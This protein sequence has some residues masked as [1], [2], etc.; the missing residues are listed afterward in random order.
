MFN[1]DGLLNKFKNISPPD[2]SIKNAVSEAVLEAIKVKIEKTKIKVVNGVVYMEVTPAIKSAI[3]TNKG[4][5][6]TETNNKLNGKETIKD[7]R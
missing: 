2:E 7:I 4:K 3:F 6:L 1:I 5:V